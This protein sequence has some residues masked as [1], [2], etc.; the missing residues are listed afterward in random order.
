MTE[1]ESIE[2]RIDRLLSKDFMDLTTDQ[3]LQ[4]IT[5]GQDLSLP[6]QDLQSEDGFDAELE[7]TKKEVDGI[8][9]SLKPQPLPI[10]LSTI[11]DLSCNYEGDSL[12]GRVLLETLKQNKPDIYKELIESG[13]WRVDPVSPK[14][15]GVATTFNTLIP[16]T[17]FPSK[18]IASFFEK[19]DPEFFARVNESLFDNLD[20][21]ILGK[22][23][24]AGS[25]KKRKLKILGFE[26]FLEFIMLNNQIEYVK[27]GASADLSIEEAISRV[28][29]IMKEK[30][31]N[32]KPCDF[33]NSNEIDKENQ[34]EKIDIGTQ[35]IYGTTGAFQGG[36]TTGGVTV[37]GISLGSGNFNLQDFDDDIPSDGNFP[38]ID[39][40]CDPVLLE[41]QI[42]GDVI[43]TKENVIE[44]IQDFCDPPEYDF[45]GLNDGLLGID[46][47]DP[48]LNPGDPDPEAPK[49]NVDAIQ[50]CIDSAID[51]AK[52]IEDST[53][54]TARWQ[55]IE[56][57]LEEIYYHYDIIKEYQ[58]NLLDFF[59][60]KRSFPEEGTPG[61]LEL[62]YLIL[63]AEER[64]E[65]LELEI[66]PA[67]LTYESA[68]ISFL[69]NNS[70]F[71]ERIFDFQ[72][73]TNPVTFSVM[74]DY[75]RNE[76]LAG[77]APIKFN[78]V[79]LATDIQ[80]AALKF[81][82]LKEEIYSVY[83]KK[84]FFD[85][86]KTSL[87]NILPERDANLET[88]KERVAPKVVDLNN[89]QDLFETPS[90]LDTPS[91][92][93]EIEG[94]FKLN[95]TSL[96]YP[97]QSYGYQF[98]EELKEFSVRFKGTDIN[99]ILGELNFNLTLF[100]DLGNPLPY[101]STKK[102]SKISIKGTPAEPM[103]TV[104]EPDSSKIRLGNEYAGNGG[105]LYNYSKS[106][107]TSYQFLT[108]DNRKQGQNDIARFYEFTNKVINSG[109]SKQSIIQQIVNDHGVLYGQLIEKSAS[110]WL[111]F[112]AQERGDNDARNPAR[113]RP[114]SFDANGDPTPQFEEFWGK[115]KTKWTEKYLENK[116]TYVIP[117]VNKAKEESKKAA[118]GLVYV[119]PTS[120]DV[121]ARI[122]QNYFEVKRRV[123]EIEELMLI[124][125]EKRAEL[126]EKLSPDAVDREFSDIKCFPNG[127]NGSG[128]TNQNQAT[129]CPPP[130]CGQP[131]SDFKGSNYL[132]SS[133][134][135]SDCP[136]IFQRCWWQQFCKDATK[137]GLL[138]YPNGLPP[139]ENQNFFLSPGPSVRLGLKY[140]PVGYLPPSFI[141]IPIANPVD[142]MPYIRIPLPMI[143]TIVPPIVIPLPLN[144]GILVIFIPFIGGFMPTPLVYLKE[145]V[146]GNSLFLTGIR[147]PRFIPR[148]SDPKLND[149][150]EKI[151]QALTYGIPDNLIPLPGFGL[152][153]QDSPKRIVLDLQ[154]N[155]TK[156]LDSIPVPGNIGKL[157][158]LQQKE[159]DIKTK[160]DASVK[161][162]K[163][164]NALV[165]QQV[166]NFEAET[167]QL[168][169]IV[170]ERK[171]VVK[172]IIV[173]YLNKGIPTP[174]SIKYPK[175]KDKLKQDTPGIQKSLQS[176]KDI[177]EGLGQTKCPPYINLLDDIK[178]IL[179]VVK[180][181]TPPEYALQNAEVSNSD[182]IFLRAG[183]SPAQMNEEEFKDLVKKI[184][185]VSMLT[186]Q[187][188]LKG[189][190]IAV[191]KKVR[192]GAFSALDFCEYQGTIA[193]PTPSIGAVP[194]P[195]NFTRVPNPALV[196]MYARIMNGMSGIQYTV[197]D[198]LPYVRNRADGNG[199]ELVIR[200]RDLK[201]I[202]SQKLGTSKRKP[203]TPERPLDREE[204]M[205]SKFP[206]PEGA[207]CCLASISNQFGAAISSFEV[208]VT[209]PPKQ[210]QISQTPGAG[211]IPQLTI[212][213]AI[214][215]KFVIAFIEQQLSSGLLERIFPEINDV[216]S[217][218]FINL[219]PQDIQKMTR[220]M[221]IRSLDPN[222]PNLPDFVNI[223]KIPVIP[224][225]RPTDMV[226]Q[227]LIGMGVP[228]PARAIYSLFWKYFKGVPKSPLPIEITEP[229]VKLASQILSKLPWPIVVLLGRNVVNIIN[230]LVFS[231]DHP[232]WR[233]MSLK[234]PYYVVYL[235]EF[236]RS[237]ADV[238]G[239]F[240]FFF[241]AAD[242]VYPIPELPSELSKAF[243]VK[244][245]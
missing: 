22:P 23:T 206:H 38:V 182:M 35:R 151:K 112:T 161:E 133:P 31:R 168:A 212:P 111:F 178:E 148:K 30:N 69:Q 13:E 64:K 117:K 97:Y 184:R 229:V 18:G 197:N 176:L 198:F 24:N 160:V 56:F 129:S 108:I 200:V 21:I 16:S 4:T 104:Q 157:R 194:G 180:I 7:K 15:I 94:V 84:L 217:P 144:L 241:G 27:L 120:D 3:V 110:N 90:F 137:V 192:S 173:D 6:Y 239:L 232:A 118:E 140:W 98:L 167:Q 244:K 80:T 172:S 128:Y 204:P 202:I 29:G 72:D 210:D 83:E 185:S 43:Q 67:E 216:N 126:E 115:F 53:K 25:R 209:F 214:V 149:P 41:D 42:T 28:E 171:N 221:I 208:P 203:G 51:K 238:S 177:K 45:S 92:M 142:G 71:N 52:K 131:G 19:K 237:A 170:A 179:R 9:E 183:K 88:L 10:P 37:N 68:K 47:D 190:K 95:F 91:R 12:Y 162:Y 54:D 191:S 79:T 219:E 121:G 89:I 96:T 32:A 8:I 81:V 65:Q 75:F 59:I 134:P 201:Q 243:T 227:V 113:V 93:A 132:A 103:I 187:V 2:S 152:D 55:M 49:V 14:D 165:D 123:E 245:Y 159:S 125:A 17:A 195:L 231:D 101:R 236:L 50:S 109:A 46:L 36:I 106:Y 153:N 240:K 222:S 196:A 169:G 44:A 166:P 20:P 207:L 175:N 70:L 138:P 211:G 235:D 62:I 11:E 145:F 122:I 164:K 242:P 82:A 58:K 105:F 139:I 63:S 85:K 147:G 155:F 66:G 189:N 86:I 220:E 40:D 102:P 213:G 78:I 1:P 158:D 188:L 130:C 48:G 223:A 61:N 143:W 163:R 77:R 124:A 73:Y 135:T 76:I 136:T 154:S 127:S 60:Q 181:P 218:K 156:I 233:R 39:A 5:G 100:T 199:Q 215:K 193:F 228:P 146:T 26:I 186:T 107:L 119:L 114:A 174:K 234:N 224:P 141:P 116:N 74:R 205:I 99:T 230:P 226:E 33:D 87:E 34:K 225:S 57:Y 150:L